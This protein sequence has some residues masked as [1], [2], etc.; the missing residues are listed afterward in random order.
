[1]YPYLTARNLTTFTHT[2]F[3]KKKNMIALSGT[4]ISELGHYKTLNL[5]TMVNLL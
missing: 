2:C 5:F 4:K 1:M 3:F